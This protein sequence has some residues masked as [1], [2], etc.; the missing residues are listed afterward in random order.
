MTWVS[1]SSSHHRAGFAESDL[2]DKGWV[3]SFI[4]CDKQ[5][6][7]T[8]FQKFE[9]HSWQNLHPSWEALENAMVVDATLFIDD[10]SRLLLLSGQRRQKRKLHTITHRDWRDPTGVPPISMSYSMCALGQSTRI[11]LGFRSFSTE[12]AKHN[13]IAGILTRLTEDD[14]PTIQPSSYRRGPNVHHLCSYEKATQL[15]YT[16]R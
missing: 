15:Q 8:K 9:D 10:C 5:I 13:I 3:E 4:F 1:C 14:E 2:K 11:K 12:R 7:V 16:R 6:A